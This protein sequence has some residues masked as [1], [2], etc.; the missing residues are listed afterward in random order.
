M[1]AGNSSGVKQKV[2]ISIEK[3]IPSEISAGMMV[4]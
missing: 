2:I 1:D 3:F 4:R